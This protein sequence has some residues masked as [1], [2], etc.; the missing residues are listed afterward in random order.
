[1]D[2]LTNEELEMIEFVLMDRAL[3]L[4]RHGYNIEAEHIMSIYDKLII[5]I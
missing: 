2:E 5:E 3:R 1:M 4:K